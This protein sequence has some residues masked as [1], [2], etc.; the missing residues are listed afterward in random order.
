LRGVAETEFARGQLKSMLNGT[1]QVPGV[2]LRPLDRWNIVTTLVALHDPDSEPMLAAETKRDPSGDGKKYAYVAEAARADEATKQ[3]YFNEYLHD[4]ARPEDWIEQS[5]GSFNYWNQSE[6]TLPF[7]NPALAALPQVKRERKIFFMLA[8][9]N[10]FIGGQQSATAQEQV[11]QYLQTASLDKDLR[12]KLLEVG[13]ELDRTVK[14]RSK[15]DSQPA[16]TADK[17]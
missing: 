5:L 14:I 17:K 10:A 1:L 4:S 6:L 2:E 7:L 11:H 3:Q 9:L 15:Y 8:W 13:D 16:A 12:L